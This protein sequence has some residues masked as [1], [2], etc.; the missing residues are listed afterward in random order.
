MLDRLDWLKSDESRPI[1]DVGLAASVD[2]AEVLLP[3]RPV[4]ARKEGR[5]ISNPEEFRLFMT[6]FHFSPAISA[7]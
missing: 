2:D 7:D 6:L 5:G 4:C 3:L 1:I